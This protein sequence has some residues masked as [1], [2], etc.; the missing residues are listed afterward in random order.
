VRLAIDDGIH[1]AEVLA[2]NP[3]RQASERLFS[4]ATTLSP[5]LDEKC[6]V[7]M[8]F[9]FAVTQLQQLEIRMKS[10]VNIEWA[11]IH[12]CE[13]FTADMNMS[14]LNRHSNHRGQ[15]LNPCQKSDDD[16]GGSKVQCKQCSVTDDGWPTLSTSAAL[17]RASLNARNAKHGKQIP[18]VRSSAIHGVK[19]KIW[20][21]AIATRRMPSVS[22]HFRSG[23]SGRI[24]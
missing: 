23:Q 7:Q 13:R 14:K 24:I 4:P 20:Q 21:T 2:A 16:C 15:L 19:L 11:T 10:I 8:S 3:D 9:D 22:L 12:K 1:E 18:D 5:V 17:S 6:D